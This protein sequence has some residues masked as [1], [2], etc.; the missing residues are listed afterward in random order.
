MENKTEKQRMKEYEANRYQAFKESRSEYWLNA[1]G[2]TVYSWESGKQTLERAERKIAKLKSEAGQPAKG[3]AKIFGKELTQEKANQ[4]ISR[5]LNSKAVKEA[6]R[7]SEI[8][9]TKRQV[10]RGAKFEWK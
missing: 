1:A 3:L 5:I 9:D 4:K 10:I 7:T 6:I 8:V 2:Q